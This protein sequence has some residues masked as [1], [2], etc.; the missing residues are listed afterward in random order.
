M[1]HDLDLSVTRGCHCLRARKRARELTRLYER[2]LRPHGLRATQ[3]SIL[4]AL[5][6]KG[7]GPMGE[8][9]EILGLERTTLSRSAGVLERNGWAE[10]AP[11]DDAR[12]RHLRLTP[13]GR[14][15]LEAAFP[16]WR[17]AQ[18]M[19]DAGGGSRG[20]GPVGGGG[21]DGRCG[22]AGPGPRTPHRAF[23]TL[24]ML[25]GVFAPAACQQPSA[26]V[27]P[28][29]SAVFVA[30]SRGQVFYPVGCAAWRSLSPDNVR[31]FTTAEDASAEGYTHT[32]HRDCAADASLGSLAPVPTRMAS[33]TRWADMERVV[34]V[35]VVE[36]VADGDTVDCVGGVRVRLLHIDAP[37][38]SQADLGLRARL[39]L[40]EVLPPGDSALVELDVRERDPYG[41][42]LAH[43]HTRRGG[44]INRDLVRRGYA[45]P[46]VIA[47][48]VR[49]AEVI[50]TAADSAR[51]EGRGLWEV[52]G[53]E[54]LPVDF[55]AGQ[56]GR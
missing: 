18:A 29:D 27:Q 41:R 42:V 56:C 31:F 12:A 5:A 8:L 3:F 45:V 23:W 1:T 19:V 33:E 14:R 35:C 47:P 46:L 4:A 20:G 50:R 37:E 7:P 13:E 21:P 53:F 17:E 30:S 39:A 51:G 52:G 2:K 40:E 44:W 34:G 16:A 22:G 43:L 6:V 10:D 38:E 49:R 28:P 15:K 48:N 24:A 54:C 36:R 55:R 26:G 9:A 32:T 11:S 25:L